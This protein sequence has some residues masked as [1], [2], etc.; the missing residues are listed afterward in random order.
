MGEVPIG[1]VI[2]DSRT[3]E[4]ISRGHNEVILTKDPTAHAEIIT[5]RRAG[6]ILGSER[7]LHCD[8]YVSLEPCPMCAH[9]ISLAR[10]RRL[11]YGAYDPKGGGVD[12]G[13][14]IYNQDSCHH[15]P[16]VYGG[17]M[18]HE[19]GDLLRRFFKQRR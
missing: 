15:R 3:G 2:V 14:R 18:E 17:L 7:L 13:A 16:D 1:A 10:I 4:I 6:E 5:L 12:H 11:Y 8:L 19:S 9:A